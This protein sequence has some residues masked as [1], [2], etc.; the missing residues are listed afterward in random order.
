MSTVWQACLQRGRCD[1]TRAGVSTWVR[2]EHRRAGLPTL[3][4]ARLRGARSFR[5]LLYILS[6]EFCVGD[7]LK[8]IFQT[9]ESQPRLDAAP[10]MLESSQAPQDQQAAEPATA[11]TVVLAQEGSR[12][13]S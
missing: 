8:Y 1:Y 6:Q 12:A 4:Q 7:S 3:G 5:C 11:L 2:R 13:V 10:R 9:N